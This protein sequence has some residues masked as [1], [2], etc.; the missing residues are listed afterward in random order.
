[1]WDHTEFV[2]F[3]YDNALG[4][5]TI[6]GFPDLKAFLHWLEGRLAGGHN[7]RFV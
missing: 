1:M 6:E 3:L 4:E 5:R 2:C 7:V